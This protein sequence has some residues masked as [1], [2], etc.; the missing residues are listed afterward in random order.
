MCLTATGI[1]HGMMGT[2]RGPFRLVGANRMEQSDGELHASD[3]DQLRKETADF[4]I[5]VSY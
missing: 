3:R 5:P 2:G 1:C 4:V